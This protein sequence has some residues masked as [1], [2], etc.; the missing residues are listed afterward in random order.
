MDHDTLP[1]GHITA[2]P[3]LDRQSLVVLL[4]ESCIERQFNRSPTSH[5]DEEV[6]DKVDGVLSREDI[7][8][9]LRIFDTGT[10]V[11]EVS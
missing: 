5:D 6:G 7:H 11:G 3:R 8:L 2:V 4:D 1:N 10:V 9:F